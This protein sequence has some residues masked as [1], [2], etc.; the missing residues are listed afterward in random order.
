M[1]VFI[2]LVFLISIA[3]L[4]CT[5]L[6]AP[7]TTID[8]LV[9]PYDSSKCGDCH[10][11]IH[12]DWKDSWHAKSIVDARVLKTFRTFILGGLGKSK[13]SK[14]DL[15][16]ICLP[17][18]APVSK[19]APEELVV[20]I[21]D[22]IVTAVDDKDAAKRAAATKELTKLDIN[23]LVCHNMKAS[24]DGNVK[25]KTIYGAK[26][27]ID[28]GPH[29][30][31]LGFETE[32]TGYYKTSEFCAQCHHG[33]PP[34]MGSDVCP[35]LFSSYKEH[36]QAH[37]GKE[38]CQG[39]HMKGKD[40]PS[41]KFPGIYD[42]EYV[43]EYIDINLSANPTEYVYHLENRVVPA[44]VT[45]V[46]LTSHSGHGMPHGCIYFPKTALEVTVK[47]QSGKV[48][49][50]K[51]AKEYEVNDFYFKDNKKGEV[52]TD[53]KTSAKTQ[54]PKEG[55]LG[56][57][58]YDITAMDHVYDA[59]EP[60]QTDSFTFV[61]PLTAGTKSV[62]VEAVYKYIYDKDTT[63]EISKTSKKVDF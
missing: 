13:G 53:P 56:L 46:K 52:V 10:D 60:G 7:A 11:D 1:R 3:V 31:E 19:D 2:A 41:H 28:K 33:C 59:L 25:A 57:N 21:A 35:T 24:P 34:G 44:I 62:T 32:I 49:F 4:P 17:C 51:T 40:Y 26:K 58:N 16:D 42:K 37:G 5:L 50:T 47:D 8:E 14:K 48:V 54:L 63:A 55:Y 9:A 29:K 6:A 39:C 18:H 45:N 30:A 36:Y 43:K 15:K 27:D 38:T 20:K 22:M 61:V 23:C 12:K